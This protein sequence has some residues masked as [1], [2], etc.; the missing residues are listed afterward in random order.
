VGK[1]LLQL[2]RVYFA[3]GRQEKAEHYLRRSW[4]V[5]KAHADISSNMQDV[6]DSFQLLFED[7]HCSPQG[8]DSLR[9]DMF[10]LSPPRGQDLK[11]SGAWASIP[12]P[13]SMDI[14]DSISGPMVW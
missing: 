2:A 13:R 9:R 4:D 6:F 14:N 10:V 12:T 7:Y 8:L 1:V 5:Y 11:M 3:A